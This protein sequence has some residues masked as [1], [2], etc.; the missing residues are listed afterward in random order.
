MINHQSDSRLK[1][2]VNGAISDIIRKAVSDI[3]NGTALVSTN[4]LLDE[5]RSIIDKGMDVQYALG[6]EDGGKKMME[7][8]NRKFKEAREGV[9]SNDDQVGTETAIRS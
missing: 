1:S 7:I 3:R 5:L 4:D 2:Q 8:I 9:F 6:F